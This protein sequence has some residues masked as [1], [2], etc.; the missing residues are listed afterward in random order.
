VSAQATADYLAILE[1]KSR[2]CRTL[3]AQDWAGF[4]ELFTEDYVLDIS[5]GTGVPPFHGRAAAMASVARSLTGAKTVH[6]VHVPEIEL[7]EDEAYAIWPMQDRVIWSHGLAL[8]GW[9]HYH[10]RWVKIDGNWKIA[11][12]RLSRLH[13]DFSPVPVA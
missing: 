3:D 9:G 7:R 12:L 5:E 13:M 4:T 8:V 11:S 2:Y 10:E 6:Q 1:A